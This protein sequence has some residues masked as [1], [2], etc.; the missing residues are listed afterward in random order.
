[1][2]TLRSITGQEFK[3]SS[4][5]RSRTFT[6][7]TNGSKYR[8]LPMSKQEFEDAEY[9]TGDDWRRYLVVGDYYL[10]K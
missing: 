5:K 8:T 6:I 7:R 2:K 9:M 4:N 1:M 10:V 3:I